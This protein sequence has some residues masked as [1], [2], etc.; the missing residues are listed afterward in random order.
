VPP[1]SGS[2]QVH[3]FVVRT[4]RLTTART[5]SRAGAHRV[6]SASFWEP[7]IRT[8]EAIRS[9]A[10]NIMNY[11]TRNV[12]TV[13]PS[14]SIDKAM[15]LMEEH[16]I[17]HLVV[18]LGPSVV[19]MLSDRDILIS[20]GW[21]L[22][23]ERAVEPR[24]NEQKHVIG[25][26]EVEQIMSRP[27]ICLSISESAQEAARRMVAFKIGALPIRNQDRLVGLVSESDLGAWLLE[28]G[29]SGAAERLLDMPVRES[30]RLHVASLAPGAPLGDAI[31]IFRRIRSRHVPV[32]LDGALVGIIS[33]RD[34]RRALGWSNIRDM[35]AQER[36]RVEEV[37]PPPTV[38]GIMKAEVISAG[39]E[40]TNRTALKRMLDHRIHALPVLHTGKLVGIITLTEFMKLIARFDAL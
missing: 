16:S 7:R 32:L 13:E 28:L 8:G 14:D 19:G 30:M 5:P 17:H 25:P 18:M 33:D 40:E 4:F 15:T 3:E 20:T 36:G 26:T 35:Q 27:A 12:V 6:R 34:V 38:A 31:D 39:P 29:F 24:W 11:A 37:G 2:E 21:M 22:A 23:S 1:V 10:M 9:A